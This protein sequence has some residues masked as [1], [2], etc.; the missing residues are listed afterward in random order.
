MGVSDLSISVE[1]LI[2]YV[3]CMNAHISVGNEKFR[4]SGFW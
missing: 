3:L 1:F 4:K 2:E